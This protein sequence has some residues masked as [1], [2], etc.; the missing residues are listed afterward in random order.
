MRIALV[1]EH[2]NPLAALGGEDAGGQNVHVA[3]LAAGLA[4]LG[5]DVVVHTRRDRPDLPDRVPTDDGYVVDHVH[6]GPA[7]E[8]PKDELAPHMPELAAGLAERWRD[9]PVDIAHAH[10]WMS[11]MATTAAARALPV[12]VPVLQTFHA[13]GVVKRRHQGAAD[14]SPPYRVEV[15]QRLLEDTDHVIATCTDEVRELRELGLRS[16]RASVIPCGVDTS[17]FRPDAPGTTP[18]RTQR[19]RLIAVGRLVPRKGFETLVQALA[20][21]PDAELL[22]LGGPPGADLAGDAEAQRL[23]AVAS[24]CGVADRVRLVGAVPPDAVPGFLAS[25]DI[26]VTGAWYEPFG[27][28]PVEAM[29]CGVPVV[30]TD[31]GGHRDT[32]I[33]GRTGELVPARRPD[34]VA[35]AL[36]RLLEE[37][38]RRQEYGAA[39]RRRALEL[40]DWDTVVERTDLVYRAAASAARRSPQREGHQEVRS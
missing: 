9:R 5:H 20:K 15:E 27:I 13:L 8:L 19:H 28:V 37:P 22:V 17:R 3:H 18:A 36:R 14:T 30:A 38:R 25:S 35:K 31:V 40:Y 24:R 34:R 33:P 29:S 11:G 21:V 12:R 1:S 10:F 4:S 32:V 2:A 6:A 16:G 23:R 26:A 7:R 39:G